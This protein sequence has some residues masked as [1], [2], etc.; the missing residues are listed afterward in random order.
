MPDCPVI[1]QAEFTASTAHQL[2]AALRKLQRLAKRC[3]SCTLNPTCPQRDSW[4]TAIDTSI[5][6]ITDAWSRTA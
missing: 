6:H 3:R 2:Y 4:Y 5:T 1:T